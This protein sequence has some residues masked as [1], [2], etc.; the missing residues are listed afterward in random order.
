ME[1]N[2]IAAHLEIR[3]ALARYC[4][5]VDRADAALIRSAF[6]PDATDVHG[7]F[8]GTGWEL[9]ERL[10]SAERG[11]P[12]AGAHHVTNV[13]LEFD[14]PDHARC[15]S[16]VLA[17]HPHRDDGKD[18]SLAIFAGRYIDRFERRNGDWKISDRR[19]VNDWSREHVAG[20]EWARL[21]STAGPYPVGTRSD[22]EPAYELFPP[23][24]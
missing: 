19:V 21:S 11:Q 4:R 12:G 22:D 7:Q 8:S 24:T 2:E 3:Q 20:D 9:A 10:A 18:G 1:L 13:Y 16:Y 17:F 6:H 5:G 15:E 23:L 14:D